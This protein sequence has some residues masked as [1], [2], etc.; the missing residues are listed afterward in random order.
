MKVSIVIPL[1]NKAP[2]VRR[3]L[4]SIAAQTFSDFEVIV[5]DDGSTDEGP[6]IVKEYG[7]ARVRLITQANAGPGPARNAGIALAQGEL[8]AFLDAD[9]EWMPEYLSES[10]SA[11]EALGPD[12]ASISSGYIEYP[13]ELS[14]E[15]MWR[16]RG[17]SEGAQR[18][19]PETAPT[20]VVS[21]LAYMS[22]WS[23]VARTPVIRKWG[24]FYSREKC[25]YAEDAY[26]WLKVLLNETVA[27]SLKPL[28]R[29]HR[30]ASGLSKNLS[31]A[32]PVEPFLKDP[33][34]IEEACPAHLRELLSRVLAIRAAH[35]ACM[36]GYWGHWREARSL[37]RRFAKGKG[38]GLP[39]YAPALVC[40][41]PV[42][43]ALGKTWRGMNTLLGRS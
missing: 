35:T 29:F 12:V 24:G 37:V 32:R 17:I 19:G 7:D 14:R 13:A 16:E 21:M 18:I 30:E 42:G 31:G 26:L 33:T 3:A 40:S 11:L 41:T 39:Y 25:L 28:V 1:Y 4:D 34:E 5:V 27:F 6:Q 38:W 36:L 20:L 23:T 8:T 15:K 43:A 22:P 10:V 9:D 2:Y